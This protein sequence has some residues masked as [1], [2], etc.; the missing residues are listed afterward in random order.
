MRTVSVAFDLFDFSI[1]FI[2]VL[3]ISPITL[4]FLLPDTFNFFGVVDKYPA[5][6]CWG[7]WLSRRE[8]FLHRLWEQ[9]P[10]HHKGVCRVHPGVLWRALVPWRLGLRWRH[11]WQDVPLTSRSLWRRRPVVVSQSW[12]NGE[13]R[14]LPT[15]VERPRNSETQ[16]WEWN[17]LGLFWTTKRADSRWLSSRHSRTRIPGWLWQKKYSKIKWNDRIAARS[18][19]SCSS[20]RRSISTRSTTSSWTVIEAKLGSSWSSWEKTSMKWKRFQGSTFDT[21]ARRKLVEDQDTILELTGKIQELQN[22]FKCMNGSRDFQ[23][24]ES[25]RSGKSHVTSQPVS[26]PLHPVPGGML[27]RSFGMS[28]RNNGPP[29]IWDT[30]VFSGNVFA[31][32]VPSSSAPFPQELN[33]WSSNVSEHTSPHVMSESQTQVQDQRCQ[34]G[35]SARNSPDPS[36]GRFFK[37]LRWRPTTTADLRTSLRQI[38]HTSDVCL[39]GDKIQDWGMYLFTSSYGSHVVDQRSG[40]GWFSGWSQIFVLCK[41]NSNAEFWS[42]RCETFFSTEQNHP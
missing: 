8:R 11:H 38:N 5:Y 28:S 4:L 33:P 27:S 17:R 14:C 35:P 2:S 16:F 22:E 10:L 21:I 36:E 20:R 25:V 7:P 1:Y 18:T 40:D 15:N 13:T 6:S 26:F 23:D 31:N 42:N 12:Q 39:L 24:A 3:F 29:S 41:R 19:L 9:R 30:L 37:G 32:P 34:S